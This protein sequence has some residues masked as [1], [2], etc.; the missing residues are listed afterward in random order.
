M[1]PTH[2]AKAPKT[3]TSPPTVDAVAALPNA[4]G[5][6]GHPATRPRCGR[7][8]RGPAPHVTHVA[9]SKKALR[10]IRKMGLFNGFNEFCWEHNLGPKSLRFDFCMATQNRSIVDPFK[11]FL[12][13]GDTM[14][15]FDPSQ[16]PF[17]K[18]PLKSVALSLKIGNCPIPPVSLEW[19]TPK[20]RFTKMRQLGRLCG[21]LISRNTHCSYPIWKHVTA[22]KPQLGCFTKIVF[23]QWFYKSLMISWFSNPLISIVVQPRNAARPVARRLSAP[24]HRNVRQ[25]EPQNERN[26]LSPTCLSLFVHLNRGCTAKILRCSVFVG[27]IWW[28]QESMY[29]EVSSYHYCNYLQ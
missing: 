14:I 2:W 10:G 27:L 8:V 26:Q 9:D 20:N 29:R 11:T 13:H 6:S 15:W 3:S 18:H 7:N 22:H 1:I 12:A 24:Q 23:T 28:D 17:W 4:M 21:S 5:S 19:V 25:A 16:Y